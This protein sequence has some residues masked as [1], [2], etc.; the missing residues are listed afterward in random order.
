MGNG[1]F[2]RDERG[3][4]RYQKHISVRSISSPPPRTLIATVNAML[5]RQA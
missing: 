2:D 5:R 3:E 1:S 4:V